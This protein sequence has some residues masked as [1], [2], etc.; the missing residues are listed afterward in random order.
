MLKLNI[1][2]TFQVPVPVSFVDENGTEQQGEFRATYRV[3]SETEAKAA[4]N[5]DKRL[6]EM[7][8]VEVSELE[9]VDKNGQVL[10]GRELLDAAQADPTLSSA[11]VHTYWE[12]AVKKPRPKT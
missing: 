12:N 7:V 8:V 3:L 6:L 2:R 10:Q 4:D 11:L 9:L 1:D 5:A